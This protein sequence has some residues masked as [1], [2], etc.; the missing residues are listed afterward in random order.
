MSFGLAKLIACFACLV[1]CTFGLH[2]AT[3]MV[4]AGDV[5]HAQLA[6]PC[7]M[8]G[9]VSA[10]EAVRSLITYGSEILQ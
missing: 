7:L 6:I 3:R 10:V 8:I 1:A 2:V 5:R 9:A 4:E